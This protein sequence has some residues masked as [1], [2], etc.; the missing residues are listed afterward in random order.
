MAKTKLTFEDALFGLEKSASELIKP[1]ITLEEALST[2]EKGIEYYN[3]CGEI[4]DSAKQR[5]STYSS[6][7]KP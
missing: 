2:F 1:D 3:K 5:I 7:V 6:E 4:L